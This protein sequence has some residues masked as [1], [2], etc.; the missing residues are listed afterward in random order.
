MV[1]LTPSSFLALLEHV[2][3]F[4]Q[5]AEVVPLFV[6]MAYLCGEGAVHLEL[7]VLRTELVTAAAAAIAAVHEPREH[8]ECND[9]SA[10]A[11]QHQQYVLLGERDH[12]MSQLAIQLAK[13]FCKA[14]LL[15]GPH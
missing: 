14:F 7:L 3:Q 12:F 6:R 4:P 5:E 11:E 15:L 1:S 13:Q 9:H 8:N 10:G 2:V